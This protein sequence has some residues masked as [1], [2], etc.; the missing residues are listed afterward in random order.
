MG[1]SA[2]VLGVF[3]ALKTLQ[4]DVEVHGLIGAVENMCAANSLN[5]EIS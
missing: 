4:P 2:V 5:W 3:H 1:G